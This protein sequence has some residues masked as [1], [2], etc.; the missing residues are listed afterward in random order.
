MMNNSLFNL[1]EHVQWAKCFSDFEM[2]VL[3]G[4]VFSC[5]GKQQLLGGCYCLPCYLFLFNVEAMLILQK[6]ARPISLYLKV[7]LNDSMW[8]SFYL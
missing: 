8:Y 7:K 2:D 1:V 5:V 3:E 4:S 6:F